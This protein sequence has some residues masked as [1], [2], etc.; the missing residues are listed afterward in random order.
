MPNLTAADHNQY[1]RASLRSGERLMSVSSAGQRLLNTYA[2]FALAVLG[3]LTYAAVGLFDGWPH[4]LVIG[5]LLL[6]TYGIAR[7]VNPDRKHS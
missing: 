4:A 3:A 5:D 2:V 1:E 7:W 6:I